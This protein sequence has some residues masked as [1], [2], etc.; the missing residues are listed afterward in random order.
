MTSGTEMSTS[1]TDFDF[2][3]CGVLTIKTLLSLSCINFKLILIG[4]RLMITCKSPYR[5]SIILNC[6]INNDFAMLYDRFDL[7]LSQLWNV[8]FRMHSSPEQYLIDINI[9]CAANEFLIEKNDFNHSFFSIYEVSEILNCKLW[10]IIN[11]WTKFSN[12]FVTH[13]LTFLYQYHGAKLP[14][15]RV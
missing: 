5:S 13:L 7:L 14:Y 6:I 10:A 9:S 8:S 12:G 15:I 4:S 1:A 2:L 11:F 3:Y